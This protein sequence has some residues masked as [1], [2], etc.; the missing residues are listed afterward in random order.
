M[1]KKF[2]DG[3]CAYKNT[4][5]SHLKLCHSYLF[6]GFY[7]DSITRNTYFIEVLSTQMKS[8]KN[9]IHSLTKFC[10]KRVQSFSRKRTEMNT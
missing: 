4:G 6:R 9:C 7:I 2:K 3:E 1:N 10:I 5:S 8:V